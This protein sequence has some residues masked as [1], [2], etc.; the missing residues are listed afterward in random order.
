MANNL[1]GVTYLETEEDN[2]SYENKTLT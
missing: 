2:Q 1:V